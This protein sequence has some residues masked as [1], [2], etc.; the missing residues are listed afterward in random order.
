M[1]TLDIIHLYWGKEGKA[2]LNNVC[3][4]FPSF[5]PFIVTIEQAKTLWID[6]LDNIRYQKLCTGTDREGKPQSNNKSYNIFLLF[7]F[8]SSWPP[9]KQE[10]SHSAPRITNRAKL[11]QTSPENALKEALISPSRTPNEPH[12]GSEHASPLPASA[13][14]SGL[15]KFGGVLDSFHGAATRWVILLSVRHEGIN[16]GIGNSLW[17]IFL[18]L[19]RL[20]CR[21]VDVLWM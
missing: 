3:N 8:P 18:H 19:W 5:F 17:G 20:G 4:T 14:G 13:L 7:I 10:H 12:L 15:E 11:K 9:S 6:S 16:S 2:Q 21:G 1:N